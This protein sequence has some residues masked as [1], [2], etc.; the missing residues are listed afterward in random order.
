MLDAFILYISSLT[1]FWFYFALFAST[2]IENI[3]PPVPGDTVTVFAAYLAGRSH[4]YFTGVF[5]ST[6]LGSI[7]GFMTYY[8][9]GRLIHPEYFLRKNF[10]I[11]PAEMFALASAWFKRYGYWIVLLNRFLSGIRS[12]IS[13]ICGIFRLPPLR[14]LA[15]TTIGCSLWNG[16]LIW[17]GYLLGDN[18]RMIEPIM[19][20]Y[21]HILLGLLVLGCGIWFYRRK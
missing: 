1:P 7:A 8:V 13:I 15:L 14:V 6:S 19:Q 16:L 21:S 9:V 11:F 5:I 20:R 4:D 17:A 12:V 18:W 3:F 2:Y 10:R